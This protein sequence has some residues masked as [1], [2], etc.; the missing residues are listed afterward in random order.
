MRFRL[1]T[2]ADF[3]A[4][5]A[6]IIESFRAITWFKEIDAHFGTLNGHDWHARWQQ[7]LAKIFAEQ[8]ILVGETEGGEIAAAATGKYDAKQALGFVD[9]L[10]VGVV[11]QGRGLG[12]EMLRA[13][14]DHFRTLGARHAQLDC[15]TSNERGMKLYESEG[16]SPVAASMK[17][18]TAL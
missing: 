7:R 9:L 6:L 5:E 12:R 14:L 16:W 13:M 10:A 8:T 3:P 1:A 15:L 18:F 4:L 17:W 11:H 2:S